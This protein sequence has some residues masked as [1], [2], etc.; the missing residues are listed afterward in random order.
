MVATKF[1]CDKYYTNLYYSHV[2]GVELNEMNE[3]ETEFLSLIDYNL[4]IPR[5]V[6]R[7]YVQRVNEFFR[8]FRPV[9]RPLKR[10]ITSP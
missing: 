6:Y 3:L 7:I 8:C 4:D 2:A 9:G 1:F 5:A 10:R